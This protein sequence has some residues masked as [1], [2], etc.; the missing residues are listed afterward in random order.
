MNFDLSDEQRLLVDTVASFVKKQ[1][2]VSRL[3]ALRDDPTGWSRDVWQR[4]GEYGWLGI[5]LP[6]AVGGSGG[7]FVD[8]AL[9]LEQLGTTLVPEPLLAALIASAPIVRLGTEEQQQRW[10]APL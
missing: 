7:S 1:S 2:P 5:L 8:V 9:V 6:E 4:M 3:R 10:L